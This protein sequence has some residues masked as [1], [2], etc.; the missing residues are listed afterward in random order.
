MPLTPIQVDKICTDLQTAVRVEKGSKK[1]RKFEPDFYRSVR[2]AL[3]TLRIEAEGVVATDIE[4]YM[5]LKER[6]MQVETDFRV[7]FQLRFSKIMRLSLHEVDAEEWG[8]LT[9]EEKDFLHTEQRIVDDLVHRFLDTG[10]P[11]KEPL[12]V[13]EKEVAQ[14]EEQVEED[15]GDQYV[16]LRILSDLPPIAQPEGDYFLRAN[17]IVHLKQNF[18]NMLVSRKWAVA[19]KTAT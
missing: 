1:V 3:R 13:K 4:K 18:A 7:F 5:K 17:D 2:E 10:E 14:V 11:S 6:I 9:S 8:Q 15:S 19:V 12:R 16:L